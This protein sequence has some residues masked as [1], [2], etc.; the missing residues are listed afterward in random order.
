MKMRDHGSP[1]SPIALRDDIR[2]QALRMAKRFDQVALATVTAPGPPPEIRL[3][4]FGGGPIVVGWAYTRSP[5]R[6]QRVVA[7]CLPGGNSWFVVGELDARPPVVTGSVLSSSSINT[8]SGPLSVRWA[9]GQAVVPGQRAVAV[10]DGQAW[11]VVG[12][13]G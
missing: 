8:P 7:A 4:G 12:V 11:Y 5:Q 3:D 13:V 1:S 10:S 2:Q 9:T 6:D